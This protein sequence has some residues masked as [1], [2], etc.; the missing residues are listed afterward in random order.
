MDDPSLKDMTEK[1]KR[2]VIAQRKRIEKL[3]V[4]DRISHL[5]R[6]ENEDKK[7]KHNVVF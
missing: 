7:H 2:K 4:E 6:F 3:A 1:E 5:E